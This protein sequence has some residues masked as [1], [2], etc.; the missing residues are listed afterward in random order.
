M[1][2]G[3]RTYLKASSYIK[4]FATLLTFLTF[5]QPVQA[6]DDLEIC[7]ELLSRPSLISARSFHPEKPTI[8]VVDG[9]SSGRFLAPAFRR[10]EDL[11]LLHV[12]SRGKPVK[13]LYDRTFWP[14]TYD[15][16]MGFF[17]D[18]PAMIDN[19]KALNIVAVLPGADSGVLFADELS[20]HLANSGLSIP[21]NGIEPGRKDKFLMA[22]RL[23]A[24]G[25]DSVKQIK[26]S[27]ADEALA[28]IE[29]E[30]LF[31]AP[32]GV[33]VIKPIR[34]AS[35][36]GVTFVRSPEEVRSTF[37]ELIGEKD[38]QGNINAEILVQEFLDGP[39]YVVNTTSRDGKHVVT[40]IWVYSKRMTPDGK[41]LIY[42]FDELLPFD[43]L[44]QQEVANYN[45]KVLS[46]LGIKTGNGHAEIK[47]VPGR[48]PVLVEMNNRMMGSSQPRLAELATGHSQIDRSVTAY[49]DPK[50]F[51][52]LNEGY[53]LKK[54]AIVYEL[55]FFEEGQ[56]E[57]L[58]S[59]AA[60]VLEK[61]PGYVHHSFNFDVGERVDPTIDLHSTGEVWLLNESRVLL[62]E[63]VAKLQ[64]LERDHAFTEPLERPARD[65]VPIP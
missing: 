19:L 5:G 63:S 16:D 12:H 39:E 42:H 65:L 18:L 41:H 57:V 15:R 30:K 29:H 56:R 3:H 22:Q 47:M 1:D 32:S 40:D 35:S 64:K 46:A 49:K 48:G 51:E 50:F 44:A 28:W 61:I 27:N 59:R 25:I 54:H 33:V 34:D 31:N 45:F 52:T 7:R 21:S 6:M 14:E 37:K 60:E 26:T 55:A 2:D 13:S 11:Q 38:S 36:I 9:Y 8:L 10:H 20:T 23:K 62:M 17:G 4:K 24:A 43:G 58:S 53:R